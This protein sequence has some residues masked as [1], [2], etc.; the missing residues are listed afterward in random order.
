MCMC[1]GRVYVHLLQMANF[2]FAD[3]QSPSCMHVCVYAC[4]Y[5]CVHLLE[6]VNFLLQTI[7]LVELLLPHASELHITSQQCIRNAQAQHVSR[8]SYTSQ[9]TERTSTARQPR[10]TRI[11]RGRHSH[12]AQSLATCIRTCIHTHAYV[13]TCMHK[14]VHHLPLQLLLHGSLLVP[15]ACILGLVL[16]QCL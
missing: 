11:T 2:L 6:M 7:S 8:G 1:V 9:H 10:R 12:S 4:T 3:A 16:E 13:R 15:H 14:C 5:A